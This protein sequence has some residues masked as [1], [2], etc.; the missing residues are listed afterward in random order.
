MII[1]RLSK[2][3]AVFG[4]MVLVSACAHLQFWQPNDEAQILKLM[5]TYKEGL[6]TGD[7]DMVMPLLADDYEGWRGGDKERV[8][9]MMR[10]MKENDRYLTM[11][12]D[13]MEIIVEG[14][15]ATVSGIVTSF[16]EREWSPTYNLKKYN[17]G[18]KIQGLSIER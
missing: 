17:D 1:A 5:M 7:A 18:W 12:L 14:D 9:E 8:G 2:M 11:N 3:A 4:L 6:E 15:T 10:R 16:G 13:E